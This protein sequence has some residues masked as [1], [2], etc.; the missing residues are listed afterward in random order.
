MYSTFLTAS[1]RSVLFNRSNLIKR[2]DLCFSCCC[3]DFVVSPLSA[4]TRTAVCV[5][6]RRLS[7]HLY[8]PF[9]K[10]PW[11]IIDLFR[12]LRIF[13]WAIFVNSNIEL[14]ISILSKCFRWSN[15]S[16]QKAKKKKDVF[17][18]IWGSAPSR[19]ETLQGWHDKIVAGLQKKVWGS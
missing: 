11:S 10:W 6:W 17:S 2:K 3:H 5:L 15:E 9:L 12:I 13:I 4:T 18:R 1:P 19:L 8:S 7:L 16:N 14:P